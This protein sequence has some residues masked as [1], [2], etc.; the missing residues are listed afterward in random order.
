MFKIFK[1]NQGTTPVIKE[2][3]AASGT[4]T[5]GMALAIDN[6]GRVAKASGTTV[7]THIS[8][9]KGTLANDDILAV[10]PIYDGM[11]FLTTFSEDGS[12]LKV[13]A[14]VTIA[15][16]GAEV[17]ATTTSGVAEIV[18]IPSAGTTGAEVIVKF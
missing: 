7:P 16:S 3:K 12:A 14:K 5:V 10:N 8:A 4:Y 2:V 13:G 9:G 17:T 1:S 11:E 6:N 18:E 15:T